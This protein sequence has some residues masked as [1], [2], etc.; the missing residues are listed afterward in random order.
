LTQAQLPPTPTTK[1]KVANKR[2]STAPH[3][4]VTHA[5]KA[6]ASE[7]APTLQIM[8]QQ[9]NLQVLTSPA[10]RLLHSTAPVL[11]LQNSYVGAYTASSKMFSASTPML[12]ANNNKA[13]VANFNQPSLAPSK[14]THRLKYPNALPE[15]EPNDLDEFFDQ[16]VNGRVQ[17]SPPDDDFSARFARIRDRM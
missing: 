4:V 16:C 15:I 1:P 10:Q 3:R 2:K 17:D 9:T 14:T 7:L 6:V 11:N 12:D 8:S 13:S 5:R